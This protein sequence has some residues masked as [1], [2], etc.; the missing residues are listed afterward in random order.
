MILVREW[1]DRCMLM[2]EIFLGSIMDSK[3][4]TF[5][6]HECCALHPCTYTL[7]PVEY[8]WRLGGWGQ[9]GDDVNL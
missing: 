7:N 3:F 6:D 8:F 2:I 1:T 5:S 9:V 4:V